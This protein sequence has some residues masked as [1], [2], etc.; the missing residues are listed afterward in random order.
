M[1][2]KS[3]ISEGVCVFS[4]LPIRASHNLRYGGSEEIVEFVNG[5]VA[6]KQ[7]TQQYVVALSDIEKDGVLFRVGTT[8]FTWT[9]KSGLPDDFQR[10]DMTGL[11]SVLEPLGDIILTGDFNA[12]RG[13]E[14]FGRLAE[15]YTDTVPAHYT[16]S[17]DHKLHRSD[18]PE[19]MI[20][21]IF[22]SKGY[23]A[24]NVE[25]VCGVS[26][27]CALVATISNN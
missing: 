18:P 10:K 3:G 26:D 23:T 25:M 2:L 8:H 27:H 12:P 13:G 15:R 7:E 22:T 17:I 5:T 16:T 4:K 9:P 24:S 11:L 20:D 21:G 6:D 14:I 19:L 1:A